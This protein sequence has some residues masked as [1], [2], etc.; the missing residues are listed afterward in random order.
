MLEDLWAGLLMVL[1][2]DTIAMT[3]IGLVLGIF[4]GS[5]PGFTT[6][7]A[8]APSRRPRCAVSG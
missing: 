7:M 6:V 2:P 4:V 3:G 1:R 5:L 8:M